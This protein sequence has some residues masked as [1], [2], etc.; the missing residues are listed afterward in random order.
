M[1]RDSIA[2][3]DRAQRWVAL[4]VMAAG[5]GLAIALAI[6]GRE[7]YAFSQFVRPPVRDL[8]GAFDPAN[9]VL[10]TVLMK[11]AV[12]LLRLST[13]S[14]RLPGLI[15]LA[16]YLWA[17][18]RL[19]LGWAVVALAGAAY[20]GLE[21]ATPGTAMGLALALWACAAER[22]LS[23][24]K[25][26]Q[27]GEMRN[28]NLIGLCLGLSVAT[29]FCFLIPSLALAVALLIAT[30]RF[31]PWMER[32]VV[33][34]TVGAFLLLV[35]SFSHASAGQLARLLLPPPLAINRTPGDLSGLIA[36]L[37]SESHGKTVRI[38]ASPDLIPVLEF[39]RA[40]Y[41][42]G[43]WWIVEFPGDADYCV[44]DSQPAPDGRRILY[45]A[46]SATLAR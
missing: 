25:A 45:R 22:A 34:G 29:N 20:L 30:R 24:C 19:H 7:A 2:S 46:R 41:H 40:R 28:F 14:L 5:V 38:T 33:T 27:R 3:T 15:G 4:A 21:Y 13:F 10:N 8:L 12:G 17:V 6:T 18:V 23:Y 11:R 44:L 36:V 35:L 1:E 26:S 31:W 43:G 32:V 42:E 39:Y 37:R 9:H 16:L